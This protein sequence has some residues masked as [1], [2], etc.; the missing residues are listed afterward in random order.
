MYRNTWKGT[1][2]SDHDGITGTT[3]LPYNLKQQ[4]KLDK[5]HATMVF[6]TLH[7]GQQRTEITDSWEL[8]EMSPTINT[9]YCLEFPGSSIYQSSKV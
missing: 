3:D 8:N 1:S 6:R 4:Q 7:I 5:V 2:T 9:A